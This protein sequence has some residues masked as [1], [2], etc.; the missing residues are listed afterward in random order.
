[1]S[2]KI[3]CSMIKLHEN[4]CFSAADARNN[5]IKRQ[6]FAFLALESSFPVLATFFDHP[7]LWRH[8]VMIKCSLLL[9]A[10]HNLDINNQNKKLRSFYFKHNFWYQQCALDVCYVWLFTRQLDFTSFVCCMYVLVVC[11]YFRKYFFFLKFIQIF[12][13]IIIICSLWVFLYCLLVDMVSRFHAT[14]REILLI[15]RCYLSFSSFCFYANWKTIYVRDVGHV[16]IPFVWC[17][18]TS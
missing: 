15:R 2:T 11:I 12:M 1:M 17:L 3:G 7:M 6:I 10:S 8:T 5:I 14:S 4:I 16:F 13:L 9:K 18:T